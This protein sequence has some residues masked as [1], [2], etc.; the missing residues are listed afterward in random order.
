MFSVKF[1]FFFFFLRNNDFGSPSDFSIF[2][3]IID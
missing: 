1:R 3:K 2:L